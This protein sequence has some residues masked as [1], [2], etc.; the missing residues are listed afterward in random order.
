MTNYITGMSQH[1]KD[2]HKD[3]IESFQ[4]DNFGND[5]LDTEERFT[6]TIL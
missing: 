5:T 2:M 3:Y 1:A 4:T 6:N